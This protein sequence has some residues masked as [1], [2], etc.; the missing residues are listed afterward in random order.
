MLGATVIATLALAVLPV[1]TPPTFVVRGG[2]PG[3]LLYIE[4]SR[5]RQA[6]VNGVFTNRAWS[7]GFESAPGGGRMEVR[8]R[9]SRLWNR[10]ETYYWHVYG[11]DCPNTGPRPHTCTER[12]VSRTR[13]FT[14]RR[15]WLG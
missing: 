15:Q 12:A 13:R 14:L 10:P 5:S 11:V 9:R 6:D 7:M 8:A 1:G 2:K 4:V 3:D